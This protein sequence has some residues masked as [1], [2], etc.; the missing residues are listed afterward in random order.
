MRQLLSW[1]LKRSAGISNTPVCGTRCA[2]GLSS[3]TIPPWVPPL[4]PDEQGRT[5]PSGVI[6]RGLVLG[7]LL[8]SGCATPGPVT[9]RNPQTKE[10]ANCAAS[11]RQFLDGGFRSQEDCVADYQSKGYERIFLPGGQK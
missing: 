11:Y 9:M 7:G 3:A 4:S 1:L 10:I 2:S 5:L 6:A 8:L